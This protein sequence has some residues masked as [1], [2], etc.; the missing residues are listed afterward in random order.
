MKGSHPCRLKKKQ[1][2]LSQHYFQRE[3][4]T[5]Q[6]TAQS[7]DIFVD[8]ASPRKVIPKVREFLTSLVQVEILKQVEFLSPKMAVV[9]GQNFLEKKKVFTFL[10]AVTFCRLHCACTTA[11]LL[12]LTGLC[13][14]S[15]I[16]GFLKCQTET[17]D[18]PSK[19]RSPTKR[20]FSWG[21]F[22]SRVK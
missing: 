5:S 3:A 11:S 7:R 22:I 16:K 2:K 20:G 17:N 19:R 21:S 4:R 6:K 8:F 9:V 12:R 18:F 10:S 14:L 1:W 13:P 15:L